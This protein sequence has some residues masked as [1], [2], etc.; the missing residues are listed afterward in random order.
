M[1]DHSY[2]NYR[3]VLQDD[4]GSELL[5]LNKLKPARSGPNQFVVLTLPAK[6]LPTG[7]YLLKLSGANKAGE[8][9]PLNSYSLAVRRN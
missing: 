7:D 3:V 4:G 1:A 2:Q 6:D 9:D 5:T 8:F